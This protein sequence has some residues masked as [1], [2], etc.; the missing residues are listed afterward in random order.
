MLVGSLYRY[1]RMDQTGQW[2]PARKIDL[3]RAI[4][5]ALDH[6]A[7]VI[8]ISGGQLAASS[9]AHP[10]LTAAV[11]QCVT[12]DVLIVAAAGNN[13]CE[14][15]HIPAAL[16]PVA[17]VGAMD[18][19]GE[20]LESSN[21]GQQ[22]V[23]RGILAVGENII[24]AVPGGG[25]ASRTGTSL[26]TPIVSGV[27]ALLLSIQLRRGVTPSPRTVWNAIL[28][29]AIGCAE[30]PVS[31]CRRLL[32]GR[33]NIVGALTQLTEGEI[34]ETS[35]SNPLTAVENNQAQVT[36]SVETLS[37]AGEEPRE[38]TQSCSTIVEGPPDNRP[39]RRVFVASAV[40]ETRGIMP[41]DC[42][43]GGG[44]ASLAYVLGQLDYDYGSEAR[45]DSFVQRQ[46]KDPHQPQQLMA[47]LNENP[48]EATAVI[49]TLT[50]DATP[51]YAIR[52][53]GPF[54]A[55]T[56]RRLQEY[57]NAQ[58]SEGA[59]R[60]SVPGVVS[61]TETLMSGQTVPVIYP[62]LRGMYNWTTKSLLA[63]VLG[64]PP[65]AKEER[66]AYE[67]KEAGVR[68]FFERVYDEMRNLGLAPQDRALNYAA[69]NAYQVQQIYQTAI[70]E[71][72][73]LD[74]IE[75]EKS[76][77]CRPGADCWDVKLTFFNPARRYE[78][79]R[80]VSR[81]TVDVTD[82]VPVT[83]GTVRQWYVY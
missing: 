23:E 28:G 33:L 67:R 38:V 69:T 4:Q 5:Q 15:L 59:E 62:E 64:K 46:L 61:G 26:A 76:P 2:S 36:A 34:M 73:Q 83:V 52:P 1:S 7:Q 41:S 82:V 17:V 27:V 56:Y 18:S 70:E 50:Q 74:T 22:Y 75:V 14:C 19:Q 79:A 45:R 63:A 65:T 11:R 37:P 31:D 43:C 39:L 66:S 55:E 60:V 9:E 68:N 54:A 72:M 13:G 40:P 8:N 51:I 80:K 20:P 49:W 78:Q 32:A 29:S 57:M 10:V 12:N 25:T 35:D 42:A 3:A 24:G 21:W 77:I 30:Q 81:M 71:Q 58:Y 16:S 47:H 48:Y 44:N 53:A 6:G